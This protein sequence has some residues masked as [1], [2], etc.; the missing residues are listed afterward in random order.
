[1]IERSLALI[2]TVTLALGSA[3]ARSAP[4]ALEKDEIK[5]YHH[6]LVRREK[7]VTALGE[8]DT[9]VYR[10]TREGSSRETLTWHAPALGFAV[11]QAQQLV[12]G[13]LG[14]HTRIRTYAPGG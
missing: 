8:V 2:T 10:S 3:G 4:L 12:K 7:L 1:M 9:L 5:H 14:F 6:T 13:K 11:V